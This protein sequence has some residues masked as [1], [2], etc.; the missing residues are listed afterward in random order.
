M[1]STLS[2]QRGYI[3]IY[4]FFFFFIW[5]EG[6]QPKYYSLQD[7]NQCYRAEHLTYFISGI[8]IQVSKTNTKYFFKTL[9]QNSQ[10]LEASFTKTFFKGRA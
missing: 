7:D 2:L 10:Y 4:F 6:T 1:I 3:Y 8:F 5:R 9:K